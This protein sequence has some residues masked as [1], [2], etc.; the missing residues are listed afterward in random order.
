MKIVIEED[1]LDLFTTEETRRFAG[2]IDEV[3]TWRNEV[4]SF[5]RETDK[6]MAIQAMFILWKGRL[7][8][9]LTTTYIGPFHDLTYLAFD[10]IKWAEV[11][12]YFMRKR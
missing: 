1:L 6:N 12:D 4:I 10:R 7:N 2:W 9:F 8:E 3:D 5:C 11:I